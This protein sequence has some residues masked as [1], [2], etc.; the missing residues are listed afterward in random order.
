MIT[1]ASS[2]ELA[3][4]HHATSGAGAGSAAN[5][6]SGAGDDS[7]TSAA[8]TTGSGDATSSGSGQPDPSLIPA[9]GATITAIALYQ[10]VERPLMKNGTAVSSDIPIIAG[11]DGMLRI[12]YSAGGSTLATARITI[13]D[14]APISQPVTL[15]GS[16]SQGS[17][18][19][20]IN[21]AIPGARFTTAASYK[22]ELL[23]PKGTA[24]GTNLAA[25]YP[26]QGSAPLQAKSSGPGLKIVLVPITY[27]ADGSNRVPDTSPAQQQRYREFVYKMYPTPNVTV[28]VKPGISWSQQVAPSGNGWG[29]L[30]NAIVS[31]RQQQKAASDEYYYGVFNA[32]PTFGSFCTGGCVAGLSMI[33]GP[34]DAMARAGIGIGFSG[35]DSA[36]AAAHEIGHEHGRGHAPCGVSQG[37][38]PAFPHPNAGIGAWGYDLTSKQLVDPSHADLMSYCHP[39]WISDYNYKAIFNRLKLVN[40]A[41]WI[42]GPAQAF[43]RLAVDGSGQ[44]AWLSPI[45]VSAPSGEPTEMVVETANGPEKKVG[46]YYPYTHIPGGL[47]L[48]PAASAKFSSLSFKVGNLSLLMPH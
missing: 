24:R 28:I 2:I 21:V 15:A 5:A 38:D 47:M 26:A 12:F 29:Q 10:A 3:D 42:D 7:A 35:D 44:G 13:G 8:A 22:V 6:T 40:N 45:D 33:A 16:S 34:N 25:T 17:L 23:V 46:Y 48:V 20:T 14:G 36:S 32:A 31:Y 30:L 41:A 27:A 19:S 37:I 39:E 18:A 11:R 1:G 9:D 43:E 4:E